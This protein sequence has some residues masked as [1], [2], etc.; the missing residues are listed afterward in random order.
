MYGEKGV[1]GDKESRCA[2]Q[3]LLYEVV[4]TCKEW[5]IPRIV[6]VMQGPGRSQVQGDIA[7]ATP[8]PLTEIPYS[9]YSVHR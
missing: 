8:L 2:G 9:R 4:G 5:M 6:Q 1:P 7:S 3:R